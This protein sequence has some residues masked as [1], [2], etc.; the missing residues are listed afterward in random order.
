M[1]EQTYVRVV[2]HAVFDPMRGKRPLLGQLDIELTERCNNRCI[3]CL[4]NLPEDDR[5]A[6]SCEMDTSFVLDVLR[7]AAE[8]GCLRVRFTGGEP[9]LRPDFPHIYLTARR[10]GMQVVLFTNGRL[11]TPDLASLLSRIP[12]GQAVEISVYGM[13]PG[14]YDT[15]AGTRGAF[16]EFWRGVKLLL[17]FKVPFIVKQALLPQ[18][19]HEMEE[20]EEWA[21]TLPAMDNPPGYAMNFDLRA[22]RD[23]PEKNKRIVALRLSPQETVSVLARDPKYVSEMQEFCGKFMHLPGDRLFS[24]GAGL[25]TCI[26]A[27]G[28]AQMCLPLHHPAMVCDLKTHSLR[29]AITE[30]FP[31]FRERKA[32]N[33]EYV[34]RCAFCFLK[35]LCGQC[36]AKSW[37]EHGTLDTPVEYLCDVAHARARNLGLIGETEH[38]WEVTD[39]QERVRIFTKKKR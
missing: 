2:S 3:H 7:Q 10:L 21:A 36:P 15:A 6:E 34:R 14:S 16:E 26:D 4:I 27:Y 35:G 25:A 28:N 19:R 29:E 11:I 5:K 13:H 20:F 38:A 23:D 18:N 30:I 37:M 17:D 9:L 33:T 12:P 24:C 31:R 22:R 1:T 39:W 8:L 32:E